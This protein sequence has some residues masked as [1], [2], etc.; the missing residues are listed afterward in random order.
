[1]TEVFEVAVGRTAARQPARGGLGFGEA[2]VH[3]AADL[4]KALVIVVGACVAIKPVFEGAECTNQG[5]ITLA[6]GDDR[7]LLWVSTNILWKTVDVAVIDGAVN[8][9]AEGTTVIGDGT[10]RTQSGN[11]R[12]YAVRVDVGAI[13]IVAVI[14]GPACG[15]SWEW[16]ADELHFSRADICFHLDLLPCR[17]RAGADAV[18]R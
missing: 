17:W 8:G 5:G 6:G 13:V 14:F 4:H 16:R 9:I 3:F 2:V 15:R 18:A 11:T 7:P 12:S 10:R 1:M